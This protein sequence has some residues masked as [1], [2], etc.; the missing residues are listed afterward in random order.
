[1]QLLKFRLYRYALTADVTKMYRQVHLDT[2]DSKYQ[3]ILWRASPEDTLRTHQLNTVTYG[4]AAA[5]FSTTRSL[6]LLADIYRANCP[7]GAAI[8]KSSFYVDDL[9]TG[10]DDLKTL[11]IIKDQVTE[12][13]RR[14][15]SPYKMALK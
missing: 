9:L 12:I 10:A 11:R 3:Y 13:L 7:V 1:M 8:I 6:N 5:P 2:I 14:A 4:V 15:L